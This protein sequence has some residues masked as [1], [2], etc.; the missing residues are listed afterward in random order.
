M[1]KKNKDNTDLLFVSVILNAVL[2]LENLVNLW[3]QMKR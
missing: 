2:V 1:K 3:L